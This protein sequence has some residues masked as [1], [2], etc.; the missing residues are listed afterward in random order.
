MPCGHLSCSTEKSL[1]LIFNIHL[2]INNF[3]S[4]L[5]LCPKFKKG[6]LYPVVTTSASAGPKGQFKETG[7][8]RDYECAICGYKQKAA[9]QTQNAVSY[10]HLRAHETPEHL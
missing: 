9:K 2:T 3:V 6:H 10:T 7:S 4:G 5:E 1:F 8:I